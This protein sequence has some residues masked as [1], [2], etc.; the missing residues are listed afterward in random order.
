MNLFKSSVGQSP[1]IH[2][3][4]PD[5]L[6]L[7]REPYFRIYETG[8]G[9][10]PR[11]RHCKTMFREIDM[12]PPEATWGEEMEALAADPPDRKKIGRGKFLDLLYDAFVGV[13]EGAWTPGRFHVVLHSGGYDSRLISHTIRKLFEKNGPEWLGEILFVEVEGEHRHSRMALEAEGW[14]RSK[15]AVYGGGVK[16]LFENHHARSCRFED[17]W[18]RQNGG[19]WARCFNYW[20]DPVDYLQEEGLIP[21]DDGELQCF[22]GYLANDVTHALVNG[23]GLDWV[24]RVLPYHPYFFAPV[25][26]EWVFPYLVP[27]MIRVLHEYGLGQQE[28]QVGS[29]RHQILKRVAPEVAK[30]RNPQFGEHGWRL[31]TLS[32]QLQAQMQRDYSSSWYGQEIAP[33]AALQDTVCFGTWWGHFG[34]ASL[35]EKLLREGYKVD[36]RCLVKDAD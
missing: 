16:P 17:A 1:W 25:K 18:K 36:G 28:S 6:T 20:Y 24:F 30:V 27:D 5:V 2:E 32:S 26:G 14:E 13:V 19:L 10:D 4:L 31:R 29:Y 9:V 22:S 34:L 35:C 33:N 3:I 15:F 7:R 23:P 21:E 12:M 11:Q 8:Y